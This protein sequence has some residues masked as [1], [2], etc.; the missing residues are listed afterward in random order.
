MTSLRTFVLFL[1]TAFSVLASPVTITFTD[2]P[3]QTAGGVYVGYTGATIQSGS[4]TFV[5]FDLMCDDF[6][7]QTSVPSGPFTYNVTTLA[8]LTSVRWQQ[9]N[10]LQNYQIAAILLFQ[11]DGLDPIQKG[12]QAGDY[13]FALW[14]VF[15]PAATPNYGNSLALIAAA[16]TIVQ[17]GG[18][19]EAYDNLRIFTP[20]GNAVSNQEFLGISSEPFETSNVPEPAGY[21]LMGSG[22]IVIALAT[23]KR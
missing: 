5:S 10:R 19:Q 3:S 8:D 17:N 21:A 1:A 16:T 20:T 15:N 6:V 11:Y 2:Q 18:D 13:N 4:Q 22:L 23:R 14:N 7:H 12:V 9:P